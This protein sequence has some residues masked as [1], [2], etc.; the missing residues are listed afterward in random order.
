MSLKKFS[1]LFGC[2][3]LLSVKTTDAQ[4]FRFLGNAL[5]DGLDFFQS[6]GPLFGPPGGGRPLRGPPRGAFIDDGNPFF[7]KLSHKAKYLEPRF[8]SLRVARRTFNLGYVY[9]RIEA[10]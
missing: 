5:S 4:L 9:S 6:K 3:V 8:I 10:G 2:L 7:L 1:V